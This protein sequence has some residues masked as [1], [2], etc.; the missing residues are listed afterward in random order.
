MLLY[1]FGAAVG[2]RVALTAAHSGKNL[3]ADGAPWKPMGTMRIEPGGTPL[4][5]ASSDEIIAG[6][7]KEGFFIW[8]VKSDQEDRR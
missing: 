5:G 3:P 7:Q 6:I 1:K 2:Q 8:P 4:I